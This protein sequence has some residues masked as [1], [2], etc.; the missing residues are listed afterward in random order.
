MTE[1]FAQATPEEAAKGVELWV[2]WAQKLGPALVDPGK[3]LGR[4]AKVTRTGSEPIRSTVI[5]MSI[6]E[7][8][9]LD[10]ALTMVEGHHHLHWADDCE[11]TVLEE[12]AIPEMQAG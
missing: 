4:A 5:G 11:I 9:N 12:M 1:R 6:L 7:A 10:D 2:N 8:Q 3:P